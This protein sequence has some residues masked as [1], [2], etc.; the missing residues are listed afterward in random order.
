[1]S[2]DY[3]RLDERVR[4]IETREAARDVKVEV[5][6]SAMNHLAVLVGSA[7]VVILGS[8]VA[9]ILTGSHA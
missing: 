9:F 6:T 7:G 4:G 8:V 1:M 3:Y 5:A 2:D